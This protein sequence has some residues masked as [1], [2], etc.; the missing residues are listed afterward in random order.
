MILDIFRGK[1]LCMFSGGQKTKEA[2]QVFSKTISAPK[3]VESAFHHQQPSVQAQPGGLRVCYG[4]QPFGSKIY[5][6]KM[7]I[8]QR[9][10][11]LI[12][13]YLC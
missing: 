6:S 7:V 5:I 1:Y 11:K 8:A 4:K 9:V 12:I 13:I 2:H 3:L 10:N